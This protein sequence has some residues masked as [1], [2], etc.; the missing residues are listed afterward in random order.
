[1]MSAIIEDEPILRL[2]EIEKKFSGVTVLQN[3]NLSI[4]KGEVHTL[5]GANGAGKSTL[6]KIIDGIH[7]DYEGDFFIRGK[8]AKPAN[9]EESRKLGVGM[10]HQELSLVPEL[11]VAENIFLGRLP[12]LKMGFVNRSYLIAETKKILNELEM[13]ISPHQLVEELSIAD[14]QMIEIAKVLSQNAE[15][16]LLDEPTSALSNTEIERL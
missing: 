13:D 4:E 1:M 14:R 12:R 5:L 8:L 3:I 2:E 16:I 6:I 11:T 9:T 7:T 10:V 15:I